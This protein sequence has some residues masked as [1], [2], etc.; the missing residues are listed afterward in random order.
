[1]P[2]DLSDGL[3]EDFVARFSCC[4]SVVTP[5]VTQIDAQIMKNAWSK[6][7]KGDIPGW[8]TYLVLMALAFWGLYGLYALTDSLLLLLPVC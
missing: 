8:L 3:L 7:R 4:Y 1:M 5:K 6:V 2:V